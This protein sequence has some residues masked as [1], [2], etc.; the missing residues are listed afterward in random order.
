M[1]DA[2]AQLPMPCRAVNVMGWFGLGTEKIWTLLRKAKGK[3]RINRN[4]QVKSNK[5]RQR[6]INVTRRTHTRINTHTPT[7]L[8]RGRR[9]RNRANE[10]ST[11]RNQESEWRPINAF[12]YGSRKYHIVNGDFTAPGTQL[13]F[14]NGPSR[15]AFREM[16]GVLSRNLIRRH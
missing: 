8:R 16:N 14:V 1:G 3:A 13:V 6:L 5:R 10:H 11:S 4:R 9:R 12:K 15:N 7:A 2:K